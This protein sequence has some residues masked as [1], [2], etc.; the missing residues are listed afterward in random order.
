MLD[1]PEKCRIFL[2]LIEKAV[3]DNMFTVTRLFFKRFL[4]DELTYKQ[5]G[6]DEHLF[7]SYR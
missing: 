7:D 4:F 5:S 6:A 1:L 2:A 3:S